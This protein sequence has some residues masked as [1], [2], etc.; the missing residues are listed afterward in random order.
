MLFF[1]VLV[2][3]CNPNAVW[4]WTKGKFRKKVVIL[5]SFICFEGDDGLTEVSSNFHRFELSS[6]LKR[7]RKSW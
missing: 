1:N 3:S 4:S 7:E 2:F 5:H 6:Q